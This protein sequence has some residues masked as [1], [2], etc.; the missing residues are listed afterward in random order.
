M[1]QEIHNMYDFFVIFGITM[2]AR[3]SLVL[4]VFMY[5]DDL[6]RQDLINS[7]AVKSSAPTIRVV[8]KKV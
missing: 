8:P 4:N 2:E 1:K 3:V 5:V 6:E 7:N